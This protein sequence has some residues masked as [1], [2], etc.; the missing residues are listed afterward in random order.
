MCWS[1]LQITLLVYIHATVYLENNPSSNDLIY[2]AVSC[3]VIIEENVLFLKHVH[4][5]AITAS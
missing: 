4:A 3:L 2:V 5:H 1:C